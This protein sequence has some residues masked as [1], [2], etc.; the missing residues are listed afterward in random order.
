LALMATP[1]IS[2]EDARAPE[3]MFRR[4]LA[5]IVRAIRRA[6]KQMAFAITGTTI[7][8][9]MTVVSSLIIGRITDNVLL[10]AVEQG[11]VT[12]AALGGAAAAIV[13]IG[14]IRGV[15]ITMRRVGAYAATYQ[16]QARDR[17]ELTDKYLELP[18][19]WHRRHPPGELLSNVNADVEAAA[20]VTTP[21]PMAIGVSVM[22]VV[23]IVILVVTDVFLAAVTLLL[24]P[25]LIAANIQYQRR[26]YAATSAAQQNRSEVSD[27]AHE[28]F[29]AALIVKTLGRE[30]TE[31]Q[32]FEERSESLRDHMIEVGKVRSVFNPLMETL[33]TLG[34][35]AILAVGVWRVDQGAMSTG[36]LVTFAYLFRLMALP[37]RVFGWLL[38]ELP[39]T[40][41]G[42]ARIEKVLND[43]SRFVYGHLPLA[44]TGGAGATVEGV[45]YVY[46]ET[47]RTGLPGPQAPPAAAAAEDDRR[48]VESI[49]LEV[50]PGATVAVVGP[51]GSGKSTVAQLLVRLFD[52]QMGR[53]A[54]DRTHMV[55]IGRDALSASTALVFQEAFLFNAS[56]ADNIS[57]GRSVTRD[58]IERAARIA[59]AHDF[60][61]QLDAGY[62]TVVGERGATLSGGQRQ[63]IALARA[64]VGEPRLLVLD[65][66]TSAVDPSVEA[67][68]LSGLAGIDT[69]VVI[70]AHRRSSILLA[71]EVVFVS[72]G[73]VAGRGTHGELYASLP[74]YRSLIDA[75]EDAA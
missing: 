32:R 60:I 5:A 22:L 23:T 40:T 46:P 29:D 19:E 14:A 39:R 4:G 44:G 67:Q 11:E 74:G 9:V 69:S 41:V 63:R 58:A 43:T 10:P 30:D 42:I 61:E 51:T 3:A 16:L 35:L 57:L 55:E 33:P 71:D 20:Y 45:A 28:S 64:I 38:G 21:L 54:L 66:A 48:G 8:A 7:Y 26:S 56:V 75:Y 65:D 72:D 70:V 2:T 6:P 52:P 15:G 25:A 62:D 31:T 1:P 47:E 24:A 68:I 34:I 59:Q 13:G 53:I 49:T 36:T 50:E 17:V 73:R 12:R 37:L 18:I 27:I